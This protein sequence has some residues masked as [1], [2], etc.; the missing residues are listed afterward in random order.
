MHT[1]LLEMNVGCNHLCLDEKNGSVLYF[2]FMLCMHRL[3]ASMNKNTVCI[4]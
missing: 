4:I 1:A 2:F 3:N